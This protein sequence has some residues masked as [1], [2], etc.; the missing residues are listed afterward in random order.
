VLDVVLFALDVD[1]A[2]AAV[3][4]GIGA[5]VVD[6]EW[7]G[8][9]LRQKGR[10]TQISYGTQ[11]DLARVR[12]ACIG[13]VICRINN[14]PEIRVREAKLAVDLGA[15]EIWLPMVRDLAEAREC[16]DAVG[17][18]AAVGMMLETREA[19]ALGGELTAL[20]LSS[21][22]VGLNDLGIDLGAANLFEP[23]ID[24][25]LER[26]RDTYSGR[27]GFAG[28]TRPECG[29]PIPQRLLLA[30]MARLECSFG[31][32]RRAFHADVAREEI[33]EALADIEATWRS[34]NE[35]A[36]SARAADHA[37]LERAVRAAT[38]A[39]LL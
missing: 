13:R 19:L 30:E 8:K 22:Y 26:F 16:L 11:E 21:V 36:P 32:A 25:T 10:D 17:E 24:G 6:W 39:K 28:V 31:V 27:L 34:L 20:P 3:R 12:A 35:R 15:D 33:G 14:Q 2:A 4:A 37:D 7:R 18:R 38:A 5:V 9:A 29:A 23:L 1:Y